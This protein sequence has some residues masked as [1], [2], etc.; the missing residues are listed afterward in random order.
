MICDQTN[1]RLQEAFEFAAKIKMMD[2]LENGL[3]S[4]CRHAKPGFAVMLYPDFA[5]YSFEFAVVEQSTSRCFLNGGLIFHG[6]HDGYS[7]GGSPTFSVS[8]TSE[9][10]WQIH[11]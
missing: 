4:L 3:I 7:N 1:G 2:S 5:P 10:G 6:S 9:S 11:T 8:L